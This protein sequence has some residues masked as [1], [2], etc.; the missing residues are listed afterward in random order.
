MTKLHCF[1]V[2]VAIALASMQAAIADPAP[3]G[4]EIGKTT[5]ESLQEQYRAEQSGLNKYT[6]GPMYTVDPSQV[7]FEGLQELTLIF[8][9]NQKLQGVLATLHKNRFDRLYKMLRGKYQLVSKKIPFVGNKSAEF[10]D[11]QTDVRL[12]APHLSFEMSMHYL[13]SDL[14]ASFERQRAREKNEKR[15]RESGQL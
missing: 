14:V 8:S 9:R 2:S 7:G 15:Q 1:F 6:M 11:G 3:F 12:N 4:L 5:P 13:H 10:R